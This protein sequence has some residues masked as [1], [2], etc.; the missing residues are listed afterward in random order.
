MFYYCQLLMRHAGRQKSLKIF[1]MYWILSKKILCL[2]LILNLKGM[3]NYFQNVHRYIILWIVSSYSSFITLKFCHKSMTFC[4]ITLTTTL[5]YIKIFYY[6]SYQVTEFYSNITIFLRVTY[7]INTNEWNPKHIYKKVWEWY[8]GDS[9]SLH[10][11]FVFLKNQ[12]YRW[13][14]Q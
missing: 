14:K 6:S 1:N 2:T 4:S 3:K 13:N 5:F 8:F 11:V 7:S 9:I 10:P 12:K